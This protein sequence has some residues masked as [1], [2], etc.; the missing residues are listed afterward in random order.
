MDDDEDDD[1]DEV[2]DKDDNKSHRSRT[3]LNLPMKLRL[4]GGKLDH[5]RKNVF[6]ITLFV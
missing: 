1:E 5:L 2:D 6:C 3:V 4:P